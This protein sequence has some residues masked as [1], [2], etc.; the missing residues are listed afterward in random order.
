M[1]SCWT[2]T[3]YQSNPILNAIAGKKKMLSSC[4]DL[5]WHCWTYQAENGLKLSFW[6][7]NSVTKKTCFGWLTA[8]KLKIRLVWCIDGHKMGGNQKA[9]FSFPQ[10]YMIKTIWMK[11]WRAYFDKTGVQGWR[12]SYP[13]EAASE[14]VPNVL[15]ERWKDWYQRL[16]F[17]CFVFNYAWMVELSGYFL[18]VRQTGIWTAWMYEASAFFQFQF[19][20]TNQSRIVCCY[21]LAVECWVQIWIS[22]LH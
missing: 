17:S 8:Q 4:E 11:K 13:I 12:V 1:V 3:P 16:C 10:S 6:T 20:K 14:K 7:Q 18:E 5:E 2:Q 19:F 15:P 22:A 21:F 9:T